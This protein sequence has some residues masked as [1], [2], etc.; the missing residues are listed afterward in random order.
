LFV[1]KERTSTP[2]RGLGP[3]KRESEALPPRQRS[4]RI[5]GKDSEGQ[6]LP[7]GFREPMRFKPTISDREEV[8][9]QRRVGD[10]AIDDVVY[11]GATRI[12]HLATA[13]FAKS[14]LPYPP[15]SPPLPLPRLWLVF[16]KSSIA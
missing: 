10:L 11:V 9:Q 3:N 14:P 5:Q 12:F 4:L 6:A 15:L 8:T 16:V 7:E 1:A 13:H 2:V